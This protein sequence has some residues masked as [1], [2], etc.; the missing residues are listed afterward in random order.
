MAPLTRPQWGYTKVG[1]KSLLSSYGG[2]LAYWPLDDAAGGLTDQLA[3]DINDIIG[4]SDDT[5]DFY[6]DSG[7]TSSPLIGNTVPLISN[8]EG[9]QSL[10]FTTVNTTND[11]DYIH[12]GAVGGEFADYTFLGWIRVTG[13]SSANGFGKRFVDYGGSAPI[14]NTE[15]GS[16]NTVYLGTDS[17]G[18]SGFNPTAHTMGT[19]LCGYRQDHSNT[20][21]HVFVVRNGT[22]YEYAVSR[23]TPTAGQNVRLRVLNAVDVFTQNWRVSDWACTS[24]IITQ[25]NAEALWAAAGVL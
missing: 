22:Y 11:G 23:F 20:N 19:V 7:T 12:L 21:Y 10:G 3:G 16:T 24:T 9:S 18:T 25:A 14:L 6:D 15:D 13:S 2:L 4:G 5:F 17:T 1:Y 8:G